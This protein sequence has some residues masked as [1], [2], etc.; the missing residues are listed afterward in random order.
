[1]RLTAIAVAAALALCAG[2]P[3]WAQTSNQP[4]SKGQPPSAQKQDEGQVFD[5][6]RVR[7]EVPQGQTTERCAMV[8]N[9][10]VQETRRPLLGIAIFHG[11]NEGK[12]VT[13]LQFTVPLG[14]YL[15]PGIALEVEQNPPV[16]VAIEVCTQQG[17]IAR[18]RLDDAMRV[19][20]QKG[21][22][23][24]AQ[25][26]DPNRRTLDVPISLKGFSKAFAALK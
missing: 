19:A 3:A 2:A 4:Q 5:D 12:R 24:K 21:T 22:S 15:P 20:M 14:L 10:L 8:Q 18:Y 13:V 26:T 9:I 17:C 1:M 16:R 6:W 7:C 23:A 25:L 11:E